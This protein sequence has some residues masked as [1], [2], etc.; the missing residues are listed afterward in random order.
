VTEEALD[1]LVDAWIRYRHAPIDSEEQSETFW[2]IEEEHDLFFDDKSEELW[3]L[4][5]KIHERDHS[6][7]IQQVLS[8]GPVENLLSKFGD[9]Y[10]ERVEDK[11]RRDPAFAR[12]LGGVWQ[13]NMSDEIWV[14]YKLFGTEGF[15]T[16]YQNRPT[17]R[18]PPPH[19]PPHSTQHPAIQHHSHQPPPDQAA[20]HPYLQP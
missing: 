1:N 8:A 2:A 15:G 11:A 17:P 14:R 7:A 10:I 9:R 16:E 20:H 19:Q 4:I 18:N 6:M 12:L 3:R 5:L 13:S